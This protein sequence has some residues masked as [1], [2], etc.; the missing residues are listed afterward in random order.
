VKKKK[1]TTK[2]AKEEESKDKVEPMSESKSKNA[3]DDSS[4]ETDASL[5]KTERWANDDVLVIV[6]HE[7]R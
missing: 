7:V 1:A 6:G 5:P 2:N 4:C 3:C